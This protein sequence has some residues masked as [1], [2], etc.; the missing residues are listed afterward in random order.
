MAPTGGGGGTKLGCWNVD[1]GAATVLSCHDGAVGPW[2]WLLMM[3]EQGP[4][5]AS[6]PR[7]EMTGHLLRNDETAKHPIIGMTKSSSTIE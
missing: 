2:R 5:G 3:S 7:D 6:E 1:M 4:G